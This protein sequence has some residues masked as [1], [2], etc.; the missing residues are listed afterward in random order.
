[1]KLIEILWKQDVDL[2]FSIDANEAEE[3]K[4]ATEAD[5]LVKNEEIE[6]YE[7]FTKEEKEEVSGIV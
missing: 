7:K 6:K 3:Q 2:G 4:P 1:M 5:L